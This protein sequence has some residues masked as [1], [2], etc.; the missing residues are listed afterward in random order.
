VSDKEEEEKEGTVDGGGRRRYTTIQ[1]G[2]LDAKLEQPD[3]PYFK[4]KHPSMDP[5]IPSRWGSVL[6][7]SDAG[8]F[9]GQG[10]QRQ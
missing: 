10:Q 9:R 2:A 7:D 5:K 3:V 8:R 1:P 4:T 6:L